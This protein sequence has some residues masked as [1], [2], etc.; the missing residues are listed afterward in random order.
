MIIKSISSF[1]NR[2][3]K[4]FT[5][6][7]GVAADNVFK[8]DVPKFNS[9]LE[10]DCVSFK[11]KKYTEGT[12][13][14]PTG[15]CAYCGSKVYD[16]NQIEAIAKDMLH[17]KYDRLSG[18]IKSILSKLSGA[19]MAPEIAL[20]KKQ[21]NAKEIEFFNKL[22]RYSA[23]RPYVRGEKILKSFYDVEG[24]DAVDLLKSN[25]QPVLKTIDHVSP[26]NLEQNNMHSD[27]NLVESCL[28][29]NHD[30]KGG[31]TFPE[32]YILFPSIKNNMPDDKFKFAQN[33]L[34]NFSEDDVIKRLSATSLLK[35]LEVL[36]NQKKEVQNQLSSVDY[37]INICNSS[38]EGTVELCKQDITEKEHEI[39]KLEENLAKLNEDKEYKA[40]V[41]RQALI[42]DVETLDGLISEKGKRMSF[43]S[44]KINELKNRKSPQ[45]TKKKNRGAK[46]LTDEE[47]KEKIRE[48]KSELELSQVKVGE[49]NEKKS[50]IL[51][52]I[53]ELDSHYPT[54]QDYT[55]KKEYA[56]RIVSTY[57]L[58]DEQNKELN[59]AQERYTSL[60]ERERNINERLLTYPDDDFNLD[61]YTKE[62]VKLLKRYEEYLSALDFVNQ[63]QNAGNSKGI[64]YNNARGS[65]IQTINN[66]SQNKIVKDYNIYNQKRRFEKELVQISK[67]KER[68]LHKI[69]EA[70]SKIEYYKKIISGISKS[71]AEQKSA[72]YSED[73]RRV[74]EK[75]NQTK[76]PQIIMKI[77]AEILLLNNTIDNLMQRQREIQSSCN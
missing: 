74:K 60:E 70:Q 75:E 63:H 5:F 33:E 1:S 28:C 22:L 58:L 46:P 9:T 61:S 23:D 15:H 38:I 8:S 41:R 45:R 34:L 69:K 68:E 2:I 52:Q 18:S 42:K 29:C 6:G 7:N 54:I 72:Q 13:I 65:L 36:F 56:E 55:A 47:A 71:E 59:G 3:Y 25:M 66:L 39:N 40:I 76:I 77:K 44:G 16:E 14:N 12:I 51:A 31:M 4:N 10:A 37:R 35:H 32:F 73:I 57:N 64:I 67:N 50:E 27:I 30:L 53:A 49:Y 43:L 26:Q 20:A 19:Q 17:L 62:E 24:D 11:A 21:A 48:Y